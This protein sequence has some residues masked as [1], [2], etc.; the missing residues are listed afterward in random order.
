MTPPISLTKDASL[1]DKYLDICKRHIR[2]ARKSYETTGT[3]ITVKVFKPNQL[4]DF[5]LHQ[6]CSMTLG[7]AEK[8]K[9]QLAR[10]MAP[11]RKRQ[12]QKEDL[13]ERII[14]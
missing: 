13:E 10:F 1:S 4:G 3:Y 8:L 14:L 5:M 2:I 9:Q 11:E 6:Y 12:E 7:E